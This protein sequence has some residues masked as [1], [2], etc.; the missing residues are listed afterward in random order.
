MAVCSRR[1]WE[2]I[3]VDV[4][5]AALGADTPFK[6]H[7]KSRFCVSHNRSRKDERIIVCSAGLVYLEQSAGAM[8]GFAG[9]Y[10]N[11][12]F[13]LKIIIY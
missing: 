13:I 9:Y 8:V 6:S 4:M 12:N 5:T 1:R 3:C 11:K 10:E 7:R 2:H